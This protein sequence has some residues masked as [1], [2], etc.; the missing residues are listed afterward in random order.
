MFL[1]LLISQYRAL[2]EGF[3]WQC[4]C[5]FSSRMSEGKRGCFFRLVCVSHSS[6]FVFGWSPIIPFYLSA[7]LIWTMMMIRECN[8]WLEVLVPRDALRFEFL[9]NILECWFVL[10]GC[11]VV[12]WLALLLH[13]KKV[14]DPAE[15]ASYSGLLQKSSDM[16]VRC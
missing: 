6:C 12:H 9:F 1:V 16:D 3:L 4:L 8:S 5:G 7:I 14:L 13:C 10:R 2:W 15:F 11:M